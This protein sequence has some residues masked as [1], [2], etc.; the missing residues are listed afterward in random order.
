MKTSNYGKCVQGKNGQFEDIGVLMNVIEL[1]YIG[2][3]I[4]N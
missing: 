1:D 4:K 2:T 3:P